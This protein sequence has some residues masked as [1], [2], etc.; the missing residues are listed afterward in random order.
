MFSKVLVGILF[1][2]IAALAQSAPGKA[3]APIAVI[4]FEL[5]INHLYVQASVNNSSSLSVIVD[6][7][8]PDAVL[9]RS[10]SLHLGIPSPGDVVVPGFGSQELTRGRKLAIN[11]VSLYGAT[12]DKIAADSI[13]LDSP[14]HVLGHTTDAIV[15]SDL[16]KKYVVEVDYLGRVLRLYDPDTYVAQTEGCRLP[17]SLGL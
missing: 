13:P 15:G 4:P 5:V 14:S 12:L 3:S 1:S 10:R 17:L 6:S 8:S 9:D 16:F 2:G 11:S 7:G